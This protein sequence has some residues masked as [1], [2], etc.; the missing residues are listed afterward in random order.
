MESPRTAVGV[1]IE[2]APWLEVVAIPNRQPILAEDEDVIVRYR[3]GTVVALMDPSQ[4]DTPLWQRFV[5]ETSVSF[6]FKIPFYETRIKRAKKKAAKYAGAL[7][8]K[9]F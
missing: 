3:N 7:A 1:G 5:G 4:P 6:D 8:F 2:S 9:N